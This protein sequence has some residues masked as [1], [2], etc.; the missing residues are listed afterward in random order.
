[1]KLST[2]GEYGLRAMLYIAMHAAAGPVTSHEVAQRQSIPE[3]Y[4]RQ[5]LAQLGKSGLVR[6]NRGPQGGHRLARPAA[7]ISLREILVSLEGHTTSVDQ[8]LTL[9]C[10]IEV[11]PEHCAIREVL[12]SV[13]KVVEQLLG[14]WTLSQLAERQRFIT[15]QGLRVPRSLDE[16]GAQLLPIVLER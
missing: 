2:K 1:M 13:K 6:S 5:I 4:L 12:L 10:N 16:P 9:R 15:E 3:P 14:D 8:I 7:A 11:G